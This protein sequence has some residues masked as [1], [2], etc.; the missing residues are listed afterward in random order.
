MR[1]AQSQYGSTAARPKRRRS[2]IAYLIVAVSCSAVREQGKELG[3]DLV[4]NVDNKQ[5]DYKGEPIGCADSYGWK[6]ISSA[7]EV[8]DEK[9]RTRCKA[10][11]ELP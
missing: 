9:V 3:E 6:W 5:L 4:N 10:F 11:A 7:S 1:A 8:W 2:R